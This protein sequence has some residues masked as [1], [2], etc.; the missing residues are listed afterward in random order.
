MINGAL[1]RP[2]TPGTGRHL[3]LAC[4]SAPHPFDPNST[5]FGEQYGPAL[6][7][8]PGVVDAWL[9]A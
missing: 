6:L 7:R 4:W 2:D 5:T 8:W 1:A 3:K 9:F